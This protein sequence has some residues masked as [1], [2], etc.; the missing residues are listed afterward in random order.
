MR[1][2]L[3]QRLPKVTHMLRAQPW[4]EF[5]DNYLW[6]LSNAEGD[7]LL[8]D[9][10][11]PALVKQVLSKGLKLCAVFITHHHYDHIDGLAALNADYAVP[12]Y[13][14]HEP[15]ITGA[16][17]RV[18]QD[19]VIHIER[20]DL[21]FR[22]LEVPGH[23]RSHVAY[24]GAGHLFCGDTLFS[25]GCGRLFEGTPAQML[26]S[27]D[28]FAAMPSETLV[29]CS[30]EYT[31]A[32]AAFAE[33]ADPINAERDAYVQVIREKRRQDLPSLP[34]RLGDELAFNPFLRVDQM[35]LWPLWA[36]ENHTVIQNRVDA[37]TV[38][39]RWKDSFVRKLHDR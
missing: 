19:D 21:S 16:T 23:T 22:V 31:L 13:A 4:P 15:R 6:T 30:H 11:D 20:L 37:F 2:I 29:C 32:N 5:D 28:Q 9:P 27:L 18:K 36:A 24:Y 34:S 25:L 39:R 26:A 33:A 3:M 17:H 7:T 12:V 14:P 35:A 38:L 8:I 10:G 1:T